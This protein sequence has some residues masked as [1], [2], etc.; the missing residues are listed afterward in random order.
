[1]ITIF[2]ASGFIGQHLVDA[3]CNCGGSEIRVLMHGASDFEAFNKPNIRIVEGD[4]TR[5]ESFARHLEAGCTVVNF[6]YLAGKSKEENLEAIDNLAKVCGK[7]RI[8]R[9]IHCST[10]VV[11]GKVPNSVIDERTVCDPTSEYAITKLEI[12]K[13]LLRGY[14]DLFELAILRPTAVFGRGGKNLLKLA[15]G[16]TQGSRIL[17][18][19]KSSLFNYR[20][21]NLVYIDN[22]IAALVFLITDEKIFEKEVF[23]ISDDEF[24]TNNYRDVEKCLLHRFGYKDYFIPPI[25]L[26]LFI[27]TFLLRAMGK[28]NSN[29]NRVYEC[30]KLLNAG[31]KKPVL[32][33]EG[34]L[35]FADWYELEFM[36][37]KFV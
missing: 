19:L 18:Y 16:L 2:G 37:G 17:N 10:A 3:L 31:F 11:A 36:Q 7:A 34:L 5:P 33:D 21:M 24:L 4:F 9:L 28:S 14:G 35:R 8:K 27:L 32:F 6:V 30:K 13:T 22:V 15:H 1:M 23:I 25:P 29:S 12:E 26:P 20:K